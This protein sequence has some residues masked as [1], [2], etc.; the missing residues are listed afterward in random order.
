MW[1]GD[2]WVAVRAAR[3][4]ADV[5]QTGFFS[6]LMTE[7]K[8]AIDPVTQVDRAAEEA[9]MATIVSHFPG[10]ARLGEEG[11]GADWREGR[12]WIVDPLDG[13]VNFV[14]RL[15]LV[16]VS[17]ALWDDG[18]PLVGV[19]I[20][21][22]RNDEFVAIAGGGA[23]LNGEPL[24]VS[25]TPTLDE[26]LVVTGFPYDTRDHA[27]AY[28]DVVE[29]VMARS[30]GTRRLGAAALDLAWVAAGRLDAY[31]EHGGR[32]GIKPWDIAAGSLLVTEAGGSVTDHEGNR[33]RLDAVATVASN[34]LVHEELRAIVAAYIPEHLR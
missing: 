22:A 11:G 4:G 19:V 33:N 25:D 21:V 17:V 32:Y 29:Q 15:P 10:D 30:R 23:T 2:V 20:D 34:G 8:G 3:A 5:V 31:W 9:I 24:H 13:T 16:A 1:E 14:R 26:S 18:E 12:V 28:L 27:R 7:M 6:E